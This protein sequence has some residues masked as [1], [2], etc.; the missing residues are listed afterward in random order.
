VL[1]ALAVVV[2]RLELLYAFDDLQR[3]APGAVAL[4]AAR[5][6][7][8]VAAS[9]ALWRAATDRRAPASRQVA[10]GPGRWLTARRARVGA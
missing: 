4:L 3:F 10:H 2:T 5:N 1:L 6:L 9:L 7:L 8:L